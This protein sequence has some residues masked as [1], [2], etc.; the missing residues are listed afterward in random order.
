[1]KRKT[2]TLISM[3]HVAVL[4][5][6]LILAAAIHQSDAWLNIMFAFAN[7]ADARGGRFPAIK[8]TRSDLS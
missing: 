1:M 8:R 3:P 4:L 2:G 7:A 6:M 5:K